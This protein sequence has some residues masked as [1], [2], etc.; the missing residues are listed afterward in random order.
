MSRTH[1]GQDGLV[2]AVTVCTQHG[3]YKRPIAKLCGRVELLI[4]SINIVSCL[5]A[6]MSLPLPELSYPVALPCYDRSACC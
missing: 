3:V 6:G 2:R 5:G 1:P 4:V